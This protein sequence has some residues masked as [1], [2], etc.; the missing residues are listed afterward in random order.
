MKKNHKWTC[1]KIDGK[2][3]V[4]WKRGS[5]KLKNYLKQ[6]TPPFKIYADLESLLSRY[7]IIIIEIIIKLHTGKYQKHIPS[8]FAYKVLCINE[9]F[10]KPLLIYRVQV[11][12]MNVLH[13]F[14]KKWTIEKNSKNGF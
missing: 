7:E 14:L 2:E 3:S 6:L 4:K 11:Q 1:F 12:S 9:K 13:E 10:N 8:S 5:T